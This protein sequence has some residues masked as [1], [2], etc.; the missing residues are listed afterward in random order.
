MPT[1]SVDQYA[2]TLA[3]WFGLSNSDISLI[4]P[5]LGNFSASSS[6]DPAFG[7]MKFLGT[8]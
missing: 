8:A 2:A 3:H 4:F 6:Y 5:N 1:T 7:Y